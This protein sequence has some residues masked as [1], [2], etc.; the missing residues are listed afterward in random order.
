MTIEEKNET[1]RDLGKCITEAKRYFDNGNDFFTV[2]SGA[3][4]IKFDM[5]S[6]SKQRRDKG[7]DEIE[8]KPCPFCGGKA[9]MFTP[10]I[11][12][13]WAGYHYVA[14][15]ECHA[16]TSGVMPNKRTKKLAAIYWN[17]RVSK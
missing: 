3:W 12:G 16:K 1:L 10:R 4:E 9:E 11:F 15:Q 8:L 17:R 6:L 7:D 5:T 13:K 14:C 2:R